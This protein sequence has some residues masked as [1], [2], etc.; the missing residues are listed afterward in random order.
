MIQAIQNVLNNK[1]F[2]DTRVGTDSIFEFSHGNTLPYTGVPYG[3]NYMAVQ[4]Y[5]HGGSWWFNP[6]HDSMEGFR[7]THQPSPWMGD[8][9]HFVILPYNYDLAPRFENKTSIFRPSFIQVNYTDTSVAYVSAST[10]DA[11]IRYES[12][13]KANFLLR[14]NDLRLVQEGNKVKGYVR[15][16]SGC[17][18]E[19]FKMYVLIEPDVEFVFEEESAGRYFIKT[20]SQTCNLRISTSFIGEEQLKYNFENMHPDLETMIESANEKWS[21]YFDKFDIN[22]KK[23][24]EHFEEYNFYDMNDK[25]NFFFN[26][27]Y[28]S[29]LFPMKHYE[30]SREG[31]KVHYDTLSKSVKEGVLYTNIGYWDAQ[32]TL[33]PFLT[34]VAK[35]ELEEIVEGLITAYRNSGYLPKWWSPDERGMM[36]GTLVDNV[37][38]DLISKGIGMKH[39]E[40]LLEAM[41][42]SATVDSGDPHYGRA[43]VDGYNQYGYVT[44]DINESVNQTLDNSLADYSIAVVAEV[45]GKEE[46]AAEYYEKSKNYKNLFDP[47]TKFLR[48]KSREGEFVEN[49]NPV[50]WGNPYTEGSSYQNSYNMYHDFPGLV[51]LF[52]SKEAFKARL[53]EISNRDT[54]W[55]PVSWEWVYHEIH[56]MEEANFGQIAIS[57]QPSFHIPYMYYYADRPDIVQL[58]VKEL[59]LNYFNYKGRGYPGDEDNGSMS[60]WFIFSSMGFYPVCPGSKEYIMGIPLWDS[61]K[62]KLSDGKELE[63]VTEENFAHKKYVQS[64]KVA[65]KEYSERKI[66]HDELINAGKIEFRL[67]LVPEN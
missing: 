1:K 39:A 45:L 30:I 8:F 57:N 50:Q 58:L 46:L 27:V 43:G 47:E 32:K 38:A 48:A 4:T 23:H 52:G 24:T 55:S 51:E 22:V 12:A 29:F 63:I 3:Q 49:F 34:L 11:I 16:F 67:G 20:E 15:N 28:R 40:E 62:I 9:S 21:Y 60:A 61:L 7:I 26:C 66:S 19:N 54:A 13:G 5:E 64:V 53:D 42:K 2:I 56:E 6:K 35:D 59:M 25:V 31:K 33:F 10:Y 18:D 37:I 36:P 41:I 14:D 17:E 44:A 65:G